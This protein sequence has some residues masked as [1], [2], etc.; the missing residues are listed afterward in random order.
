[1]LRRFNDP[2]TRAPVSLLPITYPFPIR[3]ATADV[4]PDEEKRKSLLKGAS[5]VVP[6]FTMKCLLKPWTGHVPITKQYAGKKLKIPPGT[7]AGASE[8]G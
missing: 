6:S 5:K 4:H 1:M 2:V 8:G 3:V 7:P